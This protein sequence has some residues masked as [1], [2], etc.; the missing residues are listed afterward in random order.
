M[1]N[2][3]SVLG[4]AIASGVRGGSA[5][6]VRIGVEGGRSAR[7]SPTDLKING[8]FGPRIE[9]STNRNFPLSNRPGAETVKLIKIPTYKVHSEAP[10]K[11]VPLPEVKTAKSQPQPRGEIFFFPKIRPTKVSPEP[12]LI[13]SEPVKARPE[14]KTPERVSSIPFKELI[15]ARRLRARLA[16]VARIQTIPAVITEAVPASESQTKSEPQAEI[17]IQNAVQIGSKTQAEAVRTTSIEVKAGNGEVMASKKR[18]LEEEIRRKYK[19]RDLEVNAQRLRVLVKNFEEIKSENPDGVEGE[20][21][22]KRSLIGTARALKSTIFHQ[23]GQSEREDEGQRRIEAMLGSIKAIDKEQLKEIVNGN[24]AIKETS[25][26]PSELPTQAEVDNIF[27]PLNTPAVY[28]EPVIIEQREE[29]LVETQNAVEA[30]RLDRLLEPSS[31]ERLDP[32]VSLV[33]DIKSAIVE[34]IRGLSRIFDNEAHNIGVYNIEAES[35]ESIL[36]REA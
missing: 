2:S 36:R 11:V 14:V 6:L 26:R 35:L 1:A 7:L 34:N 25:Q 20:I 5:S 21:L 31:I 29:K 16:S 28:S 17:S 15:L 3:V 32:A 33:P 24:T 12:R 13:I 30:K 22:A 9:N 27:N 18:R 8:L 10:Q 4:T 19:Q 23:R